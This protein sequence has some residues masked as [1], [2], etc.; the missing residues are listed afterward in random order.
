MKITSFLPMVVL[1]VLMVGAVSCSTMQ[2]VSDDDYATTSSRQEAPS[3]IYVQ[4]PYNFGRTII[5][6]R[7]PVSGRYYQVYPTTVYDNRYDRYYGSSIYD[8][9]RYD[10]RRYNDRYYSN[11]EQ[12]PTRRPAQSAPTAEERKQGE[13]KR[14]E[15]ASVLLGK[16]Q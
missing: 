13:Q 1:S 5:M 15:A 10:D 4:D 16:K 7:D 2:P 11:R 8:D 9:R 14:Q 6:D 3:R 12:Y